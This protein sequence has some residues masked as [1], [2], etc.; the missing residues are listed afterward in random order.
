MKVLLLTQPE[1]SADR[2]RNK[3][4]EWGIILTVQ[5]LTYLPGW[6]KDDL[7]PE[8]LEELTSQVY[9]QYQDSVDAVQILFTR[10]EWDL[11][12]GIT[13]K[14]YNKTYNGYQVGIIKDR[15]GWEDTALHE[16]MH[17]FDNLCRIY[18]GVRLEDVVGVRDWDDDVVHA[19]PRTYEY[20]LPFSQVKSYLFDAVR[21]RRILAIESLIAKLM[22]ELRKALLA[23]KTPET[24]MEDPPEAPKQPVVKSNADKLYEAAYSCLGLDMSDRAPDSLGC[25]DAVNNI[26]QKAFGVEIGG[27]TSTYHLYKALMASKRFTEVLGIPEKGD[28]VISPTGFSTKN[29]A[30]GHVGIV[31]KNKSPDGTLYIMSNDS[32]KGTWEA[33]YTLKSWRAYFGTKL[34]FPVKL[35]RLTN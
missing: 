15:K 34:G 14:Q 13:G 28:I 21:R 4:S 2:Y 1:V 8:Y 22:V 23:Q 7:T 30:N 27:G 11:P 26:H 10:K 20:D 3:L 18:T 16:L 17:T 33:N 24:I 19:K 35:Y 5:H 9:D 32:F 12:N 6:E 31:G 29:A 25:A